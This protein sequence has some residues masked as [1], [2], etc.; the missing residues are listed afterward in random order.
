[1]IVAPK[2]LGQRMKV[3]RKKLGMTQ[4]QVANQLGT[5]TNLVGMWEQDKRPVPAQYHPKLVTTLKIPK[6]EVANLAAEWS[7]QRASGLVGTK[8][9]DTQN[10]FPIIR[11]LCKEY[12]KL[13]EQVIT[14]TDL[15]FLLEAQKLISRPMSAQLITELLKNKT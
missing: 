10:V 8:T 12:E 5:F 15:R 7:N 3:A 1:M 6:Q 2:T 9:L 4:A 11:E 14:I 13:P